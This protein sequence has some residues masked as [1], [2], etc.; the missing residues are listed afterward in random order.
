VKGNLLIFEHEQRLSATPA[1]EKYKNAMAAFT[2][3]LPDL[4]RIPNA[5]LRKVA[6]QMDQQPVWPYQE[7]Y[8]PFEPRWSWLKAS[9]FTPFVKWRLENSGTLR[10]AIERA[11]H[12]TPE[13]R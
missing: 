10:D 13:T 1:F 6:G 5:T 8:G 4:V 9:G 12:L 7:S 2:R 3:M 11:Q